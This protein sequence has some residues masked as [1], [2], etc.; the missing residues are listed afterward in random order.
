MVFFL[1]TLHHLT[2]IPQATRQRKAIRDNIA[3]RQVAIAEQLALEEELYNKE[4]EVRDRDRL[5]MEA[6]QREMGVSAAEQ[7]TEKYMLKNTLERV[8]MLDPTGQ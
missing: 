3:N 6:F 1:P 7:R 8:N 2:C 5:V 4:L